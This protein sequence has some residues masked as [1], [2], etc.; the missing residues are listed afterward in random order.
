MINENWLKFF[1]CNTN[2]PTGN[3]FGY[4]AAQYAIEQELYG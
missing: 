3:G 2:N 1:C 4:K